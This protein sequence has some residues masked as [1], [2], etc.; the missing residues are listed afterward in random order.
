[1]ESRFG[2]CTMDELSA[3]L[4]L[5]IPS[6]DGL[7]GAG[8]LG[9]APQVVAAARGSEVLGA[10]VLE[11]LE[12]LTGSRAAGTANLAA[13]EHA[14]AREPEAFRS[15]LT[16]CLTLYYGNPRVREDLE[17]RFRYPARAPQPHGYVMEPF[18]EGLLAGQRARAPF[19]RRC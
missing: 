1:M 12:R 18:D 4:D 11:V 19:W 9:L 8:G 10:G 5:L 14:E 17:R 13:L 2:G 15:L 16:L 6:H 3:Y 7:P